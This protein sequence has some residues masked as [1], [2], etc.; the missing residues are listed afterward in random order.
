[1]APWSFSGREDHLRPAFDGAGLAGG[2]E[3]AAEAC[4]EGQEGR[5]P[6]EVEGHARP[7]R[8]ED[9]NIDLKSTLLAVDELHFTT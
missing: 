6:R 1:M 2:G 8:L 4:R 7:R 9:V 3:E 5:G